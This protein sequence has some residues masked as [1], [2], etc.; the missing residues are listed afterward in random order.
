[1]EKKISIVIAF[2]VFSFVA[3][4]QKSDSTKH[5]FK[6]YKYGSLYGSWGYND[7]WYTHS[8]IHVDQPSM[9]NNFTFQDLSAHDRIGWD[10]LFQAQITIPQYNYRIGYFIDKDQN[11]AVEL[12][13]DHTKYVVS[14]GYLAIV[15]GKF[16]GRSIDSAVFINDNSLYYQLNN[17]ANWFL[18]N[19]VRKLSIVK[20][21]NENFVMFALFKGG[22]GPNVPHVD[23]DIFGGQ[24]KPHFQVGGMNTGFEALVRFTFF[25]HVFLEY[26]NKLDYAYYWGLKIYNGTASQGFGSYEMIANIGLTCHLHKPPA[27]AQPE[28]K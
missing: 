3:S 21:K 20:T 23:D 7:E 14:Q 2:C 8:N 27:V 9:Q 13:F 12:N 22:V 26:S 11:W 4:A 1:M 25:K 24:N 19:L 15:N 10:H 16:K 5:H 6:I 17:G 28:S 18:F